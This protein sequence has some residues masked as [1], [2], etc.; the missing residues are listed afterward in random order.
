M[1]ITDQIVSDY[2]S[3]DE[4]QDSDFQASNATLA[5]DIGTHKAG[6]TIPF[7]CFMLSE[8]KLVFYLN[9]EHE[10]VFGLKLTVS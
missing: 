7:V 3:Y 9:D 8:S 10:E 2:E 6:E 5:V 4:I 1:S